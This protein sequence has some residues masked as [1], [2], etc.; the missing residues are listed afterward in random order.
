MLSTRVL[1]GGGL[2]AASLLLIVPAAGQY[3]VILN[4]RVTL[5][6]GSAPPFTA[7][8]Q[9]LCSDLQGSAPG[10][11]TNKK[12]EFQW[13]MEFDPFLTRTCWIEATYP[14]YVSSRQDI[15]GVNATSHDPTFTLPPL[16]LSRAVP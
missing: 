9:R 16:I 2:L 5:E 14:G 6:D 3:K 12:G 4:G 10:P 1:P 13:Q 8:T 15:S 7:G 11:I